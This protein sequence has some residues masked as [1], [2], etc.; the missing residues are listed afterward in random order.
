MA[1]GATAFAPK[2]D[3]V[4]LSAQEESGPT[5][6]NSH[7]ID[8]ADFVTDNETQD[9]KR[10]L[11]QR[12]ISLIAIAGAIVSAMKLCV[13]ISGTNTFAGH[14]SLLGFRWLHPDRRAF[15]CTFG[16]CCRRPHR[17][18]RPVRLGR[19]H[20]IIARHWLVCQTCGISL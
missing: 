20:S 13:S 18:L 16:L 3:G 1:S 17:M 2:D 11:S 10:G 14:W 15:R 12:H 4:V 7:R 9:L 8:N 19:G 6:T 5:F